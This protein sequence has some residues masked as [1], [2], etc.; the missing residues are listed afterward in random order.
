MLIVV[1]S[2][3]TITGCNN[4]KNKENEQIKKTTIAYFNAIKN[5]DTLSYK[6]EYRLND[7]GDMYEFN[8]I[9]R[10]YEKINPHN[11]LLKNIK[12]KDTFNAGVNKKYVMFILKKPHYE[13]YETNGDLR[14]YLMFWK[15]TGYDKIDQVFILGNMPKWEDQKPIDLSK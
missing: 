2:I 8:F 11:I 7:G 4:S 14:M 10:N 13:P 15:N 1:I 9:K 3:L 12:V 5:N 6:K